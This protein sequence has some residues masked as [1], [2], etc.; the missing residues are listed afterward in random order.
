MRYVGSKKKLSKH[1]APIIQSL[2]TEDTIGYI[3]P[4]VGGANL[5]ENIIHQN[6]IGID[7]H[8]PLIDLLIFAQESPHQLPDGITKEDYLQVRDNKEEYPAYYVGLVGF[9]GSYNAKYFGGY[10]GECST[11]EGVRHYDREA[12]RN[13]KA[14]APK[15]KGIKF[16]QGSFH[17]LGTHEFKGY[18]IY[19]DIPYRS[20]TK[21]S[22]EA[23]DY[24]FFYAWARGMSKYNTVIVSEYSMPEEGFECIWQKT[25]KTS[26][27]KDDNNKACIER[28]FRVDPF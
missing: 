23:F 3:E 5:I 19:C 7:I 15:L 28:L 14:Q 2:I 18:V 10:S 11:K 13:L 16:Y 24:E 9:C 17:E 6:R 22:T 4:F 27:N 20:T 25:H 26:L 8:G 1:L 21:Y 12:I